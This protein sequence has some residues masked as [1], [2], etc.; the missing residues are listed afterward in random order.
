MIHMDNPLIERVAGKDPGRP[1][2]RYT[3]TDTTR[4]SHS[5]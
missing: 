1:L 4:K 2:R 3:E 5:P